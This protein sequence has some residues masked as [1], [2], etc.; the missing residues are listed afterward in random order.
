MQIILIMEYGYN[1][2]YRSSFLSF[3]MITFPCVLGH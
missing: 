1:T 3:F 2:F